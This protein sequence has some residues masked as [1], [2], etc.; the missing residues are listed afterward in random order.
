MGKLKAVS[1]AA[2]TAVAAVELE[3]RH[4]LSHDLKTARMMIKAGG[5]LQQRVKKGKL[6]ADIWED[7]TDLRSSHNAIVFAHENGESEAWTFRN[8]DNYANK[9]GNALIAQGVKPNDD[10]ALFMENR[11][12]FIAIWLGITKI[13]AK[14]TMVNTAIK[15][16]GL[17][18][19]LKVTDP[20]IVI[21]GAE[22]SEAFLGVR[23][24]LGS[25]VRC[26]V[27]GAQSNEGNDV[28]DL[29]AL[30]HSFPTIRPSNRLRDGIKP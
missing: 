27:Q 17:V 12:Q 23:H 11:A 6:I 4:S 22:L 29:D 10:I 26:F 2:A 30:I 19:C 8:M 28:E 20:K 16:K 1:I 13:G 9:V 5:K 24:E 21:Y 15:E 25:N 3:R 18:H 14:V 7:I